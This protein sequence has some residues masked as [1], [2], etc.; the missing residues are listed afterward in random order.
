[1][2]Q[3]HDITEL[4][5]PMV[6]EAQSDRVGEIVISQDGLKEVGGT[7]LLSGSSL[8]GSGGGH[9]VWADGAGIGGHIEHNQEMLI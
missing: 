6:G 9:N 4:C 1:M 3:G 2:V 8:T 5:D 7:G